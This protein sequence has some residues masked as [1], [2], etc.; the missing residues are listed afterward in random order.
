MDAERSLVDGRRAAPDIPLPLS[1][2]RSGKVF[3]GKPRHDDRNFASVR[4]RLAD[5]SFVADLLTRKAIDP[6]GGHDDDATRR[7]ASSALEHE[8]LLFFRHRVERG[9]RASPYRRGPEQRS[10]SR[11]KRHTSP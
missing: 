1:V 6:R 2:G 10:R 9:P 4:R 3:G 5:M 8:R 7:D 11:S